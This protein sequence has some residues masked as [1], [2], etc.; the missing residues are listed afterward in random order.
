MTATST[1]PPLNVPGTMVGQL[2]VTGTVTSSLLCSV[3]GEPIETLTPGGN[4]RPP[5]ADAEVGIAAARARPATATARTM[6]LNMRL[7]LACFFHGFG[8]ASWSGMGS[9]PLAG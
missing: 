4:G 9:H 5:A 6:F 7:L 2:T 3:M 8:E 1:S